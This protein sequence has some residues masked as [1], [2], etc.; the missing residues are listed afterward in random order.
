[1]AGRV[2]PF[3]LPVLMWGFVQKQ[4]HFQTGIVHQAKQM[5]RK[6]G[7]KKR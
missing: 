3:L 2:S 5:E 1:M 4:F 6:E 7:V